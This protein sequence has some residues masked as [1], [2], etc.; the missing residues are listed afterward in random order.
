LLPDDKQPGLKAC[1]KIR[2][3]YLPKS[4]I[5]RISNEKSVDG[6]DIFDAQKEGIDLDKFIQNCKQY[7]TTDIDSSDS[8]EPINGGKNKSKNIVYHPFKILGYNE[9]FHYFLPDS[10]PAYTNWNT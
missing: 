2:K 7:K 8:E 5:L 1:I 4:K 3:D 10:A 9:K 6:W